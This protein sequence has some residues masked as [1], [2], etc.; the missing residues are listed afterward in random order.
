MNLIAIY[1]LPERGNEPSSVVANIFGIT[2]YE[3]VSRIKFVENVPVIMAGYADPANASA[4]LDQLLSSGFGALIMHDREIETEENRFVVRRAFLDE[5]R[6]R[7]ESRLGKRTVNY[8]S[9]R[10]L[11]RGT[12]IDRS[13]ETIKERKRKFSAGR[14]IMTAGLA[15]TKTVEKKHEEI[16]E[17]REGFLNI[18][19]EDSSVITFR[20]NS[21]D[22]FSMS[23]DKRS[24]RMDNF[25]HFVAGLRNRC[26]LAVYDESL[27]NRAGQVQLLGPLFEP[28]D[29][30][31]IAISLIVNVI[32]KRGA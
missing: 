12:S 15:G 16:K 5:D 3:A 10:V 14:A 21:M 20:E 32:R 24:S 27:L 9:I 23:G 18:Y 29:D 6:L 13:S 8:E 31:D 2:M 4:K 11:L 25:R 28:E 26:K 7:L 17:V 30:I 22:Y 19:D 1:G